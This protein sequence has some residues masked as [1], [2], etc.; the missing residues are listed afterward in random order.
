MNGKAMSPKRRHSVL[1]GRGPLGLHTHAG[2]CV[3]HDSLMLPPE[4]PVGGEEW[5]EEEWCR[6]HAG[7]GGGGVGE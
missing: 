7:G 2:R 5:C 1:G 3:A 4:G 6:E